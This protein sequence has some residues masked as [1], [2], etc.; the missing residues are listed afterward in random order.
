MN[1][2]TNIESLINENMFKTL[3]G[4]VG[5][6]EICTESVKYLWSGVNGAWV[7][8]IFSFLVSMVSFLIGDDYSKKSLLLSVINIFPIFLCSVGVYEIGIEPFRKE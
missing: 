1:K 2:L 7:S 8:F 5:I 4:C 6:V 3:I